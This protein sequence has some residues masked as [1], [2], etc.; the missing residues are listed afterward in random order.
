MHSSL[1]LA[2][3]P[4]I[5]KPDRATY[6]AAR[7][8]ELDQ[9]RLIDIK[10]R[11]HLGYFCPLEIDE[12]DHLWDDNDISLDDKEEYNNAE[13]ELYLSHRVLIHAV[14]WYLLECVEYQNPRRLLLRL[15]LLRLCKLFFLR[16]VPGLSSEV[17]FPSRSSTPV[18]PLNTAKPSFWRISNFLTA[19]QADLVSSVVH[20]ERLRLVAMTAC[21]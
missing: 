3:S 15:P 18:V 2:L 13:S 4:T 8:A 5:A 16:F 17:F 14:E 7:E 10:R 21:T 19:V 1:T 9:I 12:I 11:Q 6:E 20:C